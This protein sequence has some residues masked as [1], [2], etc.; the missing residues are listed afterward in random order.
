[1]NTVIVIGGGASGL[2]AAAAAA[3]AGA[4]T[5]LLEKNSACGKKLNITGKGRGNIT[6]TADKEA[7][8]E[9]FGKNGRFLY[10]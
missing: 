10:S 9:A 4:R 7:F 6:N 8:V 1:M 2:F 3:E 5:V